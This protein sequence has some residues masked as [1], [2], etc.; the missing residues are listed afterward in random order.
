MTFGIPKP[1]HLLP[2]PAD[3]KEKVG[4]RSISER[5][6]QLCIDMCDVKSKKDVLLNPTIIINHNGS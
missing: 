4:N 5:V 6:E 1:R 2:I 3:R